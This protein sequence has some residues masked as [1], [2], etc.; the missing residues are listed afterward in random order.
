VR[1]VHGLHAARHADQLGQLRAVHFVVAREDVVYERAGRRRFG[2]R[3]AALQRG[4]FGQHSL[5]IQPFARGGAAQALLAAAAEIE[6]ESAKNCGCAGPLHG[7]LADRQIG[8]QS[9]DACGGG[10]G[11]GGLHGSTPKDALDVNILCHKMHAM[12]VFCLTQ[13]KFPCA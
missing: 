3:V 11:E 6:L 1:P 9:R 2:Q 13:S 4:D 5:G 7:D 10:A 12:F 8:T